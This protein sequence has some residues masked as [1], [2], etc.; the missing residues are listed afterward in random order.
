MKNQIS[1]TNLSLIET[2]VTNPSHCYIVTTNH[3]SNLIK[4]LLSKL[5]NID[6]EK[7]DIAHIN[8]ICI[9]PQDVKKEISIS[10]IREVKQ[11]LS[12][13]AKDQSSH[14]VVHIKNGE[15]LSLQASN[16]LLKEL[17]EPPPK[18]VFIIQTTNYQVLLPTIRSR[19]QLLMLNTSKNAAVNKSVPS[20]SFSTKTSYNKLKAVYVAI[21]ENQHKQLL[22]DITYE[23][24][25]ESSILGD[26]EQ[27]QACL[28]AERYI[29]Q[30]L[31]P[32]LVLENLA[33][34]LSVS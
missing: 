27:L 14:R 22:Q 1:K 5:L 20:N 9:S 11:L 29:K 8:Y 4:I 31:N 6:Y 32:R 10:Q 21:N 17:E 28:Q 24:R 7:R 12:T 13:T 25:G 2:V 3:N 33:L 18:T 16:A 34:Q 19:A 30:N 23:I 26:V 15:E